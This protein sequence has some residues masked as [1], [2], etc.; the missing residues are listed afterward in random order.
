MMKP[1][2]FFKLLQGFVCFNAAP[3]PRGFHDGG[4][5]RSLKSQLMKHTILQSIQYPN[6]VN[7]P[8]LLHTK[9]VLFNNSCHKAELMIRYIFLLNQYFKRFPHLP[10][11]D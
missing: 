2:S 6:V 11:C 8:N 1:I 7:H 9:P 3:I 10:W 5:A 4:K